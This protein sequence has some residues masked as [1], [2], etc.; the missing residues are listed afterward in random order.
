MALL[1][2]ERIYPIAKTI[3]KNLDFIDLLEERDFQYA[4]VKK[5][6]LLTNDLIDAA[7]VIVGT[8]SVSYMLSMKGEKHWLLLVDYAKKMPGHSA[9]AILWKF[10]E[11]SPSLTRFRSNK[12]KRIRKLQENYSIFRQ[13]FD[14]F[15]KDFNSLRKYLASTYRAGVDDKTI[16]F[17][18]KMFYYVLKAYNIKT[19]IPFDIPIPVDHRISL[20][21]LTSGLI[22]APVEDYSKY[23][24][25]LRTK[26][27]KLVR[28]A[29][30]EV[31]R[32]SQIP[33]LRIDSPLWIIGGIIENSSYNYSRLL[34]ELEKFIRVK[35]KPSW[36]E[37]IDELVYKLYQ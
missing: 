30:G 36:I 10:V 25:V 32:Q 27:S 12:L 37:L 22:E 20:V 13:E 15:V 35:P 8:A 31:S 17:A 29:W 9:T 6:L 23:A 19:R 3:A 18:V 5:I 26:Y 14:T 34:I 1:N 16:V 24:N 7:Y 2:R 28:S 4:A 33:A 21:S 11:E